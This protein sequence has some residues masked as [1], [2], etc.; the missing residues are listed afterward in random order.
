MSNNSSSNGTSSSVGGGANRRT[1]QVDWN[2]F[3]LGNEDDGEV[4]VANFRQRAN[5]GGFVDLGNE[6]TYAS[7]GHQASGA[8]EIFAQV[9]GDKPW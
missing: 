9:Q 5:T 7:G 6:H 4:V 1:Q 8:T 2:R 3:G